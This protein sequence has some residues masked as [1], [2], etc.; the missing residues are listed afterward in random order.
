MRLDINLFRN[1]SKFR[2]ILVY[3]LFL[4]SVVL[5]IIPG[6]IAQ[7]I[8]IAVIILLGWFILQILFEILNPP[9]VLERPRQYDNFYNAWPDIKE[10]I[11][12]A[13]KKG[14]PCTIWWLD[15][16]LEHGSIL[17]NDVLKPILQDN[18]KSPMKIEFAMLDPNW[19]EIEKINPSWI[20]LAKSNYESLKV[21]LD[22][23]QEE[24]RKHEWSIDLSLYRFLP[25]IQGILINFEHLFISSCT[26]K[27]SQMN[28]DNFYELHHFND[29]FAG[30]EKI[31]QFRSWFEY[32]RKEGQNI[33]HPKPSSQG[34]TFYITSEDEKK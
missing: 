9:T 30:K 11:I 31:D 7:L 19:P 4:F 24:I 12:N 10:C 14:S 22:V 3:I 15:S 29:H 2:K 1:Y 32:C 33:N 26:W 21:F 20:S 17:I 27:N 28:H 13:F 5:S 16:S 18:L 34:V 6:P 23:Y 8:Q 25:N